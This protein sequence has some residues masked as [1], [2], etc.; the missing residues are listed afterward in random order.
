MSLTKI[1]GIRLLAEFARNERIRMMNITYKYSGF[2]KLGKG[3]EIEALENDLS[4]THQFSL[5]IK[6]RNGNL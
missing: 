3:G 5:Y 6:I 2:W 4:R 1:R